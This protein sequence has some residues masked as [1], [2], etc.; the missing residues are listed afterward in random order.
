MD[1]NKISTFLL[2]IVLHF[3]RSTS[4]SIMNRPINKRLH[5]E[6]LERM[7]P[8]FQS[9]VYK[10]RALYSCLNNNDNT[11]G[12]GKPRSPR[13][14]SCDRPGCYMR[15]DC[16]F[17][18]D[19]LDSPLPWD[20]YVEHLV[21]SRQD[22]FNN[23]TCVSVVSAT[24]KG[25]SKMETRR[26]QYVY[27]RNKCKDGTSCVV[28]MTPGF[29]RMVVGAT[30]QF[31]VNE[32]CAK[33]NT[34]TSFRYPK[35][36]IGFG[37]ENVA[38]VNHDNTNIDLNK[39]STV[40]DLVEA[41]NSNT[42]TATVLPTGTVTGNLTTTKA[43]GKKEA[44]I[45]TIAGTLW[46]TAATTTVSLQ[47]S[48]TTAINCPFGELARPDKPYSK[49]TRLEHHLCLSYM[50]LVVSDSGRPNVPNYAANPH[51]VKCMPHHAKPK[52]DVVKCDS[53]SQTLFSDITSPLEILIETNQ[54]QAV[55]RK[56][57]DKVGNGLP[58]F[59]SKNLQLCPSN[60]R[61][62]HGSSLNF[63]VETMSCHSNSFFENFLIDPRLATNNSRRNETSQEVAIPLYMEEDVSFADFMSTFNS[64]LLVWYP[65]L[66]PVS[67]ASTML[68]IVTFATVKGLQHP[69]GIWL[70]MITVLFFFYYFLQL[71]CVF[72]VPP[73]R[74][75]TYV[76]LLNHWCVLTKH[77]FLCML[78]YE[79]FV[80][81]RGRRMPVHSVV[82]RIVATCIVTM[83]VII[84][85]GWKED[86]IRYGDCLVLSFR[87]RL[88]VYWLP[89][90]TISL[91]TLFT[92]RALRLNIKQKIRR[93]A[94]TVLNVAHHRA[95]KHS[96]T[97]DQA[98]NLLLA[99]A[100]NATFR[101]VV[102]ALIIDTLA[103]VRF[104]VDAGNRELYQLL[105]AAARLV[106]YTTN[107]LQ[108]LLVLFIF[109][110]KKFIAMTYR[111]KVTR[112]VRTLTDWLCCE[113][114]FRYDE[115]HIYN[116]NN[117]RNRSSSIFGTVDRRGSYA[118]GHNSSLNTTRET[119]ILTSRT[120]RSSVV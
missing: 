18:V 2:V 19:F 14:C 38:S 76:P 59:T 103:A 93:T 120:S 60:E 71:V 113:F 12:K 68:V 49:C 86:W 52:L 91:V 45:T 48:E 10:L 37:G 110:K 66:I 67:V 13:C 50:A 100:V 98:E 39:I 29:G 40:Q 109:I 64:L 31:Y 33:C 55:L 11:K 41:I 117:D 53:L 25:S 96:T 111:K 106:F 75:R 5:N 4:S 56:Y 42:A 77:V 46:T 74:A 90:V 92:L 104:D 72:H 83:A 51:C 80:M 116:H 61:G 107:G 22:N 21:A 114:C 43:A 20:A 24:T 23:G 17:D 102:I 118:G 28:D 30:G 26:T 35:L 119:I 81:Y 79:L 94:T 8:T 62:K 6:L 47:Q 78:T 101:Y 115:Q 95:R 54:T 112:V 69:P 97:L 3:H 36:K 87:G 84:V 85:C 108:G 16:C 88:F 99:K 57:G 44:T 15:K 73:S 32:L 65:L 7:F 27:A 34:E 105:N 1:F 63:D 89:L 9:S 58:L 70:L 82:V